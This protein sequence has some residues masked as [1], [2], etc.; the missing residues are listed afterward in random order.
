M[1]PH[2]G[3][4]WFP[5]L[6]ADG[7]ILCGSS[8]VFVGPLTAFD[9]PSQW[10]R[11]GV[12]GGPVWAG[13]DLVNFNSHAR[14]TTS[15]T[16]SNGQEAPDLKG[17]NL[18]IGSDGGRWFGQRPNEGADE[19]Q[20]TTLV[21]TWPSGFAIHAL[22]PDG[23]RVVYVDRPQQEVK[24]LF[25]N[26]RIPIETAVIM[27]A[28]VSDKSLCWS[29]HTDHGLEV[30]GLNQDGAIENWTVVPGEGPQ[31]F[32]TPDGP[33]VAS[34]TNEEPSRIIVRPAGSKIGYSLV[35]EFFY[36][37]VRFIEDIG[38]IVIASSSRDGVIQIHQIDPASARVDLRPVKPPVI[39]IRPDVASVLFAGTWHADAS[40]PGNVAIGSPTYP[41]PHHPCVFAEAKFIEAIPAARRAGLLV[42][43][44]NPPD[45]TVVQMIEQSIL[46]SP[47]YH[48]PPVVYDDRAKGRFE[49]IRA[50]F[51]ATKWIWSPQW[52]LQ[53]GE[54]PEAFVA[55]VIELAKSYN[56]HPIIPTIRAYTSVNGELVD[57]VPEDSVI[58]ALNELLKNAALKIPGLLGWLFF[59]WKRADG[60]GLDAN[61]KPYRPRVHEAVKVWM[62]VPTTVTD[63]ATW[64]AEFCGQV[65]APQ[66]FGIRVD[67]YTREGVAPFNASVRYEVEGA[68]AGVTVMLTVDDKILSS[69]NE[70]NG[71]LVSPALQPGEY[72]L[73]LRASS[74]GRETRT[75]RVRILRVLPP[76]P[77]PIAVGLEGYA[78]AKREADAL[79][80]GNG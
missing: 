78:Q 65:Q 19:Y 18:R 72:R 60:C 76:L 41:V 36:P 69:T 25:L 42:Y 6:S 75:E 5:R 71:T 64:A 15:V 32:D 66:P 55:R 23:T 51:G 53:V 50:A 29:V 8:E 34:I 35:G 59:A 1:T 80:Q 54:T 70:P 26:D 67:D 27:S 33:W 39:I 21:K 31:V 63:A 10:R 3:N 46:D 47:K 12:E 68:G 16:V 62:E 77:G 37:H 22:S 49:L 74:L 13:P 52:Y 30:H 38:R 43:L 73:G 9:Y 79:L 44:A 28:S 20:G 2:Q 61:G 56:G 17:Y 48:L 14:G 4:G 57:R 24:T 45:A 11:L 58:A 40:A 7:R